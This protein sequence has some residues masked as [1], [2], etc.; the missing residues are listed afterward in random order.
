MVAEKMTLNKIIE[1]LAFV[2][3]RGDELLGSALDYQVGDLP[4]ITDNARRFGKSYA[5]Q[6]CDD[7]I[8][9]K[10]FL[11]LFAFAFAALC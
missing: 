11:Y 6:L 3:Q 10:D 1:G 5:A 8:G 2:G 9:K 4:S 7:T